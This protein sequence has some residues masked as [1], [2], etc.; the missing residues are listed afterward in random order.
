MA[1]SDTAK[2]VMARVPHGYQRYGLEC[3]KA[4]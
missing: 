1:L 4:S 2:N 3:H